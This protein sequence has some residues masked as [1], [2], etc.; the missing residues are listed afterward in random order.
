MSWKQKCIWF[1]CKRY[2]KT[3]CPSH[4]WE[5]AAM[6]RLVDDEEFL[7]SFVRRQDGGSSLKPLWELY[8]HDQD[9]FLPIADMAEA[10]SV[11]FFLPPRRPGH[12]T[13]QSAKL[14]Q[15]LVSSGPSRLT[16]AATFV[17]RIQLHLNQLEQQWRAANP[18]GWVL[19]DWFT[20]EYLFTKGLKFLVEKFERKVMEQESD[21]AIE[22]ILKLEHKSRPLHNSI[23]PTDTVSGN[24]SEIC[25]L[26][27]A[28]GSG[29]THRMFKMLEEKFGFY[30]VSGGVGDQEN[31]QDVGDRLYQPRAST[32]SRDA[33]LLMRILDQ[34]WTSPYWEHMNRSRSELWF[35]DRCRLLLKNRLLL[36]LFVSHK[37][38]ERRF[39]L[40]PWHWLQYQLSCNGDSDPFSRLLRCLFF[41]ERDAFDFP[42]VEAINEDTPYLWCFDEVQCDLDEMNPISTNS[43]QY[44]PHSSMST[45]SATITSLLILRGSHSSILAGTALNLGRIEEEVRAGIEL[46]FEVRDSED[47]EYSKPCPR[48]LDRCHL[49]S[50]DEDLDALLE[51]TIG[52]LLEI[53]WDATSPVL[54]TYEP[55]L[56]G[57]RLGASLVG[58]ETILED[59]SFLNKFRQSRLEGVFG[60]QEQDVV[61][62]ILAQ[63]RSEKFWPE[64]KHH[65]I[66]LRGRYRWSVCY[67]EELFRN[68]VLHGFLTKALVR[69]ASKSVQET[70]KEPLRRR[71]QELAVSKDPQKKQVAT[72]IFHMAIQFELYGR[73]RILNTASAAVLIEQALAYV[74][75]VVEGKVEVCLAERLVID[76]VMEYLRKTYPPGSI[77]DQ[78][79]GSWQYSPSSFGFISEDRLG[80][81]IYSFAHETQDEAKRRSFLLNFDSVYEISPTT[82]AG[83]TSLGLEDFVLEQ[84]LGP[85]AM[86]LDENGDVGQWLDQVVQGCPRQ[87]FLLPSTSAGP[88]LMFVLCNKSMNPVRRLVC[89]VQVRT[90]QSLA[91]LNFGANIYRYCS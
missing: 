19:G 77:T 31:W 64:I 43:G 79:L 14:L 7:M 49:I 65:G 88:D 32:A 83:L 6:V 27:A 84:E 62:E 76:T 86:G 72:D 30:I 63:F 13:E 61:G 24:P 12:T 23:G 75:G 40:Q 8:G 3:E 41:S 53:I 18:G 67:I 46:A 35:D 56:I 25:Y 81:A 52:S 85:A 87:S 45:L 80:E 58:N 1:F 73:S 29:K 55:Q 74:Q 20:G 2:L 38:C 16:L 51:P 78:N 60:Q 9:L 44:D 59:A 47:H 42:L 70:A 33:K 82:T 17:Q 37:S 91:D 89:A 50:N 22:F 4:D 28:A 69:K 5:E 48:A 11:S 57:S 34:E 90:Q 66:A 26:L 39:A 10:L 36:L 15:Y 54:P 68:L 71:I 21:K